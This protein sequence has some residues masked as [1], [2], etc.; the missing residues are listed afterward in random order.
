[1]HFRIRIRF[2]R[3]WKRGECMIG[4]Q[5]EAKKQS[6]TFG[7]SRLTSW[8]RPGKSRLHRQICSPLSFEIGFNINILMSLGR[9]EYRNQKMQDQRGFLDTS[10]GHGSSLVSPSLLHSIV[11]LFFHHLLPCL[12]LN[13]FENVY[14]VVV[15]IPKCIISYLTN[16]KATYLQ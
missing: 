11:S 6:G 4:V 5:P 13:H 10:L 3:P 1:M 14:L 16:V 2:C 7:R 15:Y 9:N 12:K 8:N